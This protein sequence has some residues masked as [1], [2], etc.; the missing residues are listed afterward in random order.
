MPLTIE[1]QQR[2]QE[3]EAKKNAGVQS[4]LGFPPPLSQ[5]QPALPQQI[6]TP[7]A[8]LETEKTY[9][10]LSSN[11]K[12]VG[13]VV[14]AYHG[15]F[16]QI[17]DEGYGLVKGAVESMRGGDFGQGYS[18]GAQQVRDLEAAYEQQ[19]PGRAMATNALGMGAGAALGLPAI[20]KAT[21]AALPLL[22]RMAQGAK[23]ASPVGAV[24]GAAAG[25]GNEDT[26][27]LEGAANR[28]MGGTVGALTGG[29]L[30]AALPAAG[31]ALGVVGEKI[32]NVIGIGKPENKANRLAAQLLKEGGVGPAQIQNSLLRAKRM[33]KPVALADVA[34]DNARKIGST[35]LQYPG[36]AQAIKTAIQDRQ[37]AQSS[38]IAQ[39]MSRLAGIKPG[40]NI[41][42]EA[43]E[44]TAR[45]V[46]AGRPFY[47]EVHKKSI[48]PNAQILFGKYGD[49]IK[50]A[51]AEARNIYKGE[52]KGLKD[53]SVKVLDYAKQQ[54]DDKVSAAIRNGDNNAARYYSKVAKELRT[55]VDK[56]FPKYAE[57]RELYG[58]EAGLKSAMEL[59]RNLA[60]GRGSAAQDA[61]L[62]AGKGIDVDL[63]NYLKEG[64]S[65]PELKALQTGFAQAVRQTVGGT[66]DASNAAAKIVGNKN[67]R[68]ALEA[69][70]GK[71]SNDLKTFLKSMESE[72]EMFKTASQSLRP[73][74]TASF[75]KGAEFIEGGAPDVMQAATNP[76]N[77]LGRVLTSGALGERAQGYN[78]DTAGL[79]AQGLMN[80]DPAAALA[81]YQGLQKWQR[82]E[83]AK[84]L[85]STT[86]QKIGG[87]VGASQAATAIGTNQRP[88]EK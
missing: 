60:F 68:D 64:M 23:A 28:F 54:M 57:G 10:P 53:N 5:P 78:R 17:L 65:K 42:T 66:G 20:K 43:D 16:P 4:R 51:I 59:G 1:Q 86:R 67:L 19:F 26:S 76:K 38:R 3:L 11:L 73:S 30:G 33:G 8:P 46:E 52:L 70:F 77:W 79:L 74:Q 29:A 58:S 63:I 87:M 13:D 25:G 88:Q 24:Y 75:M 2:L 56:Y 40:S 62:D 81:Y 18:R 36:P 32:G 71:N 45:A 84:Q 34:G 50:S 12:A 49:D 55:G 22:Q 44:I 48:P 35:A 27:F 41:Y 82:D 61:G 14:N 21:T 69:V 37:D 7:T 80:P 39:D 31:S 47:E 72:T 85:L 15:A 6:T 83:L 9:P